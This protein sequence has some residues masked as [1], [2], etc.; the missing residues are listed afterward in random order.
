MKPDVTVLMVVRNEEKY[1]GVTIKSILSQTY[2]NFT[3]IIIN[4]GSTDGTW[5]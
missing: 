2:K 1:V 3:F 5:Q 4:D